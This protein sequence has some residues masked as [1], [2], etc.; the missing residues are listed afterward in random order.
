MKAVHFQ[1]GNHVI[2]ILGDE[3]E[4]FCCGIALH[5]LPNEA[6]RN[7]RTFVGSYDLHLQKV[8]GASRV[9]RFAFHLKFVDGNV[10]LESS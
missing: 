1:L 5:H 4:L 8:R 6:N 9:D 2:R 10:D 3:A 7:R